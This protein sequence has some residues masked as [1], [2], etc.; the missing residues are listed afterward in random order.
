MKNWILERRLANLKKTQKALKKLKK[1]ERGNQ[2]IEVEQ[3]IRR[4]KSW[5]KELCKS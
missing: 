4:I 1:S 3:A 5:I 2:L